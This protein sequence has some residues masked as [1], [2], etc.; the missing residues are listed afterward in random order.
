[1][2]F[3][4]PSARTTGTADAE[5]DEDKRKKSPGSFFFSQGHSLV[6]AAKYFN[7]DR[8]Q[9]SARGG[10]ANKY[11]HR[12]HLA[13]FGQLMA[14][15]EYFLKDFVSKAI[16]STTQLDDLVK[17]QKWISVDTQKLLANRSG[18][19]SIGSVLVHSTQSWHSATEVNSRYSSLFKRSPFSAEDIVV[20]EKLWVLRHSV[21]HNAGTVI[22]YDAVR[23][24]NEDLA[25][26]A[27]DLDA[28]F[29]ASTFDFLAPL[30][31]DTCTECGKNLLKDYFLVLADRG[32]DFQL[33]KASYGQLKHLSEYV[34][35]RVTD[36]SVITKATYEA[37]F[38]AFSAVS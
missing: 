5:R 16:D 17:S 4:I 20:I 36:L 29:L 32:P 13:L 35:S 31:K 26:R 12:I 24:G 38:V 6:L 19:A 10:V 27:A 11:R 28:D 30:V 9:D 22:H 37:D 33:D 18:I 21:A 23:I 15:F 25:N 2:N 14:S 34:S 3:P 1:M 8:L 7:D